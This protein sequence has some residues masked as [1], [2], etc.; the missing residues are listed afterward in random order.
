MEGAIGMEAEALDV[1]AVLLGDIALL[2]M[3][4][5]VI[6]AA[7]KMVWEEQVSRGHASTLSQQIFEG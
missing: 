2:I 6:F 5:L 7:L 4:P 1:G 3:A